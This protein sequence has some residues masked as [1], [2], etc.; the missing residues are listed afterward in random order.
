MKFK[1]HN[2]GIGTNVDGNGEVTS[3]GRPTSDKPDMFWPDPEETSQLERDY[4]ELCKNYKKQCDV[5]KKL[6]TENKKLLFECT[7]LREQ[8]K[9]LSPEDKKV[10][11]R[12]RL[13]GN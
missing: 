6:S 1:P 3:Y 11:D 8:Q 12:I 13:G 4:H 5:T 9:G 7:S 2:W 10:M